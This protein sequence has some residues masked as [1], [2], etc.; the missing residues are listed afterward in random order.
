MTITADNILLLAQHNMVYSDTPNYWDYRVRVLT[1]A[2]TFKLSNKQIIT[3]EKGFEWDEASIPWIFSW[4]FP[5][6]GKYAYSA[7]V[8][9]ALYYAKFSNRKFA[10]NEF[11]YWMKATDISKRQ[12]NI[13]Y[14]IVR[15]FGWTYWN[16]KLSGRAINNQ[17]L[18]SIT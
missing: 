5:K 2:V 7:L 4:A 3:L 16:A 13:R 18:I 17:Q 1:E 9:D 10:D 12:I 8:H 11:K 15:L 14:A 6:S